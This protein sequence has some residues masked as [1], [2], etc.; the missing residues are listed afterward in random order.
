MNKHSAQR[1]AAGLPR[2]GFASV[3]VV[4]TVVALGLAAGACKRE[5]NP[6]G[7]A[8]VTVRLK[9]LHPALSATPEAEVVLGG[10]KYEQAGA[11]PIVFKG[12]SSGQYEV[13]V[14][15]PY[16]AEAA[17]VAVD[18]EGT[19][20]TTVK[21]AP[22]D[23]TAWVPADG[24]GPK[25][26]PKELFVFV[27]NPNWWQI[28]WRRGATVVSR[29]EVAANL[30]TE[31]IGKEW[32]AHD[33]GKGRAATVVVDDSTAFATVEKAVDAIARARGLSTVPVVVKRTSDARVPL[34]EP[35]AFETTQPPAS[36]RKASILPRVI[37]RSEGLT[38]DQIVI[39]I[40]SVMPKLEACYAGGLATTPGLTGTLAARFVIGAD[41]RTSNVGSGG[42]V[43]EPAVRQ[44]FDS[45]LNRVEYPRPQGGIVVVSAVF[46][47]TTLPVAAWPAMAA[48]NPVARAEGPPAEP[49]AWDKVTSA[50][51][52]VPPAED[53]DQVRGR[54]CRPWL[55]GA[56]KYGGDCDGYCQIEYNA[57]YH[58][59]LQSCESCANWAVDR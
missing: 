20:E 26:P 21:V 50:D 44:C 18:G 15:G 42:A 16:L 41:G 25:E 3:L 19:G 55:Q 11:S 54:Q 17:T 52:V 58:Y 5:T 38:E 4:L 1:A 39:G 31:A 49:K 10:G 45:V 28:S 40:K 29:T 37:S 57:Q 51:I 32:G 23:T 27:T 8:L 59:C 7:H 43:A 2:R 30:A 47:L 36:G 34:P 33:G 12:V 6:E 56:I 48:A 24:S 22:L 35:H 46:T 13:H 14:K 9:P 53:P